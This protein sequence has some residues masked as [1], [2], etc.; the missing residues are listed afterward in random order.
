LI[1]IVTPNNAPHAQ[2]RSSEIQQQAY[3]QPCGFQVIHDLSFVL[4]HQPRQRL[5]FDNQALFDQE[6]RHVLT[7]ERPL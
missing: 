2:T 6:V 1:V 5:Y 4:W 7:D 3:R